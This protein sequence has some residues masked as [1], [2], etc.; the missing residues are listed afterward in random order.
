M[1]DRVAHPSRGA[2]RIELD[3]GARCAYGYRLRIIHDCAWRDFQVEQIG[4]P[5]RIKGRT[6]PSGVHSVK[7]RLPST[8]GDR[9]YRVLPSRMLNQPEDGLVSPSPFV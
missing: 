3:A 4:E 8:L 1:G 7:N 5:Q 2:I 9:L 6:A